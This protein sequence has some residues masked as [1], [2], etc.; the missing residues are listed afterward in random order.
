MAYKHPTKWYRGPTPVQHG[1]TEQGATT[2]ANSLIRQKQ[3]EGCVASVAGGKLK[4]TKPRS[5]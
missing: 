5:R 3:D 4:F 1:L 2:I